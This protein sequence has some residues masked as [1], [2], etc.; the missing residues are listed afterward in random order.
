[1]AITQRLA[2]LVRPL[3]PDPLRL[4]IA[5][6]GV[7][8]MQLQKGTDVKSARIELGLNSERRSIAVYTGHLYQGRGIDLIVRL[9]ELLSDHL[10]LVVGGREA[11]VMRYR[12][13]TNGVQNLCFL[14]FKP[15]AEVSLYLQA[16]DVLLMPYEEEVYT[17]AGTNTAA[18][19]SPMKM[20]EYMAAGKPIIASN[21]PVLQEVLKDGI[22]ALLLPYSNTQS[23]CE[24]LRRLQ[25]ETKLAATLSR[26]AKSD[27]QE[28]TWENRAQY[29]LQQ[30][31]KKNS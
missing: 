30:C 14:G 26:Q 31:V 6:D 16:A 17:R 8:S 3:I 23:W 12:E 5:P 11:D 15:P 29:I 4:L 19:A 9:A 7:D 1:M 10:F 18:F 24:A 22:N 21:L 28:Y 20:F 2:N 25:H 13:L 27:V